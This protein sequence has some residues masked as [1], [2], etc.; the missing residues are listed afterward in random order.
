M[1]KVK[2]LRPL[3]GKPEGYTHE[4]SPAD[5]KRLADRGLVE[6][7]KEK[8]AAE[9]ENKQAPAPANKSRTAKD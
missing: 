3:D 9:P 1:Q 7:V 4:F 5:A 6:I 2:S 8:A